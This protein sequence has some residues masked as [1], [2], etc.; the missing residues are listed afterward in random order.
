MI[1][2]NTIT[3]AIVT[4]L[5]VALV[6]VAIATGGAAAQENVTISVDDSNE[7]EQC[8]EYIDRNTRLC[9]A[10]L[11]DGTAVLTIESDRPQSVTLTDAGGF[12]DGG[13]VDRSTQRLFE[14]TNTVRVPVTEA[15]G[16]A[17]VSIETNEV[18]YAIPLEHSSTM[19]GGPWSATDA[20]LAGLGA[21][22]S[23]S[24]VS[25]FL[26]IQAITGRADEPER[27]A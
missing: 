18:L 12:V 20:Q 27:K 19:L 14:G 26:A 22:L 10:D 8:T 24:F 11:D 21:A 5:L 7:T 17:G 25:L 13:Q 2:S 9:D 4:T 15:D 16:F 3:P 1:F 6:A 23:V